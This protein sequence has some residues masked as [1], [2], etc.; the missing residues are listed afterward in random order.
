VYASIQNFF[1]TPAR[2]AAGWTFLGLLGIAFAA[3]G[4]WFLTDDGDGG[5]VAASGD[6]RTA[7]SASTATTSPSATRATS[8][9]TPAPTASASPSATVTATN[10]TAPAQNVG[11]NTGNQG[12]ANPPPP[13]P[14]PT[15]TP[16]EAPPVVS[17]GGDYCA[18]TSDGPGAGPPNS[19]IGLFTIGG[20]PA[21]A[22]SAVSLAFDGVIG[23]TRLTTDAGGYR[24]DYRANIDTC[25]NRVGASISIVY[26]GQFF[27]SGHT[28]GGTQG[29]AARFDLA[30]P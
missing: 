27:P 13:P 28:V 8:T 4:L 19:V 6:D 7:T 16:T 5:G 11:G 21:P 17:A 12:G 20:A 18:P 30:I 1:S 25:A 23:P 29:T 15:A 9:N 26:N 3:G 22:G 10:T 2:Q 14:E 24:V